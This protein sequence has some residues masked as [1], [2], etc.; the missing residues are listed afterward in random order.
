MDY[1]DRVARKEELARVLIPFVRNLQ[2]VRDQF[3]VVAR[4]INHLLATQQQQPVVPSLNEHDLLQLAQM[5]RMPWD[6]DDNDMMSAGGDDN[7]DM[8]TGPMGV[9]LPPLSSPDPD[10]SDS[11]IEVEEDSNA[12]AVPVVTD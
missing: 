11:S 10:D 8:I 12:H 3:R 7:N 4:I 6:D 1:Y 5:A 9:L 2:E